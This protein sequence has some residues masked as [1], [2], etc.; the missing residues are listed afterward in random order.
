M[1]SYVI[2]C[3]LT[4]KGVSDALPSADVAGGTGGAAMDPLSV[5]REAITYYGGTLGPTY[6]TLGAHDIVALAELDS[7]EDASA[8]LMAVANQGIR[9][10]TLTAIP[11]RDDA[12][13]DL[14]GATRVVERARELD[15]HLRGGHL[16]GGQGTGIT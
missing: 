9:T 16:R 4:S 3:N 11:A 6:W 7:P 2:L 14:D 13:N 12:S 1:G 10:T 8:V 5:L 15:G